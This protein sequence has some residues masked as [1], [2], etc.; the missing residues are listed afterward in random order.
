MALTAVWTAACTSVVEG[1]PVRGAGA[2]STEML[3]ERDL[4]DILLDDGELGDVLGSSSIEVTDEVD[5]MTDD[6][7][8]VSDPDC[9]GALYT[10]EE[11]VYAGTGYTAVL[12]WL[13][14]ESGAEYEHWVEETGVVMPSAAAAEEFIVESEQQWQDCAGRDVSVSDGEDWYDW[15]LS[16][17]VRAEGILSQRSTAVDSIPWQCEHAL[18]AVSNVVL[19]ASVCAE[20]I[21]DEA[22]KLL[23]AMVAKVADR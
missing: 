3:G 9:I 15:D 19:E 5:R 7:A 11:P 1:E 12:T 4:G 14:S 21:D 6:T 18:V 23:T 10:A 8:D 16:D 22:T 20:R 2:S 17:A 13:A